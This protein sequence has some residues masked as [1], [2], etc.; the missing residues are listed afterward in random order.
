MRTDVH[1]MLD[2]VGDVA[3][4]CRCESN[5][6]LTKWVTKLVEDS[7][8]ITKDI[9]KLIRC[10]E[11]KQRHGLLKEIVEKAMDMGDVT[12]R[13]CQSRIGK[14]LNQEPIRY[15][16]DLIE[17]E[18]EAD[19][20]MK[21]A[22]SKLLGSD[23]MDATQFEFVIRE[24]AK[25]C[26]NA[27]NDRLCDLVSL[28]VAEN[29]AGRIVDMADDLSNQEIP[30]FMT[31]EEIQIQKLE[32]ELEVL[33]DKEAKAQNDLRAET[34]KNMS[35]A[36]E[37]KKVGR[38]LNEALKRITQLEKE[39]KTLQTVYRATDEQLKAA[40]SELSMKDAIIK[41]LQANSQLADKLKTMT[42]AAGKIK[43]IAETILHK[44]G[45]R[46]AATHPM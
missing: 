10:A 17:E 4:G 45:R 11:L 33:R 39:N 9:D 46:L 13:N 21:E 16:E 20:E 15:V 29:A 27:D 5:E 31:A 6:K 28:V 1:Q 42:E 30:K 35:K 34:T 41:D 2:L 43:D 3:W 14:I 38:E 44:H 18:T 32:A 23:H 12:A 37:M 36:A 19:E 7:Q 26:K 25:T 22:L 40:Q 24:F 8:E